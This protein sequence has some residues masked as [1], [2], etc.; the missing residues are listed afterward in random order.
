MIC[1]M[2]RPLQLVFV[3]AATA[4]LALPSVAQIR[5]TPPSVTSFGPGR[6]MTPG[7]PASVTSL[8]PR[9]FN[10]FHH[11]FGRGGFGRNPH[12]NRFF[13]NGFVAVPVA[14]PVFVAPVYPVTYADPAANTEFVDDEVV[15]GP[16]VFERRSARAYPRDCALGAYDDSG[17]EA[18]P[19]RSAETRSSTQPEPAAETK[20][21]N[22]QPV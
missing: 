13:G 2:K 7:V 10:Q 8:G 5:G 21:A 20:P 22:S 11:G 12:F 4:L 18:Q 6:S 17:V 3:V 1:F 9:G 19:P 16:T 15:A 14:V